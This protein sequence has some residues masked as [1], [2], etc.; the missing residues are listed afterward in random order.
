[1]DTL[2][3]LLNAAKSITY[4]QILKAAVL[5][6]FLAWVS[7]EGRE[8]WLENEQAKLEETALQQE[9]LQ[10]DLLVNLINES[11]A[12]EA[13][14]DEQISLLTQQNMLLQQRAEIEHAQMRD[15]IDDLENPG[16]GQ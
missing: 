14:Q 12:R 11:T 15:D 13:K 7:T 9:Y 1:M 8:Q 6:A 5:V 10:R 3:K 2:L 4:E 16:R